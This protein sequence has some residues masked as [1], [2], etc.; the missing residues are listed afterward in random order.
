[1]SDTWIKSSNAFC[2]YYLWSQIIPHLDMMTI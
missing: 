1:M 2:Y